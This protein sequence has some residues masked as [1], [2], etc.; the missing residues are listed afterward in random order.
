METSNSIQVSTQA[1][2]QSPSRG[3]IIPSD[4]SYI[5]AVCLAGI[6]GVL[7]VHHFY[8]G[9]YLEGVIDFG[10]FIIAAILFFSGYPLWAWL[11]W[12]I[13]GLHSFIVTIMLLTGSVK[14][15]SGRLVCYPGQRLVRRD[16]NNV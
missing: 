15:G 7:G 9:R 14:D 11:I 6:F 3:H 2:T 13:D 1:V 4:K 12:A 10:M 8:L 5:V 16:N